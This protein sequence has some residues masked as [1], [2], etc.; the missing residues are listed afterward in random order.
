[1]K[2]RKLF[3]LLTLF[4]LLLAI[5]LLSCFSVDELVRKKGGETASPA[6]KLSSESTEEKGAGK[7][8]EKN[9]K[10]RAGMAMVFLRDHSY[11]M[12][13]F[14][15]SE[16][17]KGD[18]FAVLNQ[19]PDVNVTISE[20]KAICRRMGKHLCSDSEWKNGCIG[21][22]GKR[23]AYGSEMKK[24]VCN[25]SGNGPIETGAMEQCVTDTGLYDMVG[26]VMEWVVSEQG[27]DDRV[28]A[29]GG[30]YLTGEKAD[31]FTTFYFPAG[32]KSPQ[33]GFRC[34]L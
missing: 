11:Q 21:L 19:K 1:M 28:V 3:E 13:R 8:A 29:M 7:S 5:N 9:T 25:V 33:I 18:Y 31:C 24:D 27:T 4:P 26:N 32:F 20:A 6:E 10:I 16:L 34:C 15:V 12:D 17:R 2:Q 30:S 14:E 23:Y 22:H